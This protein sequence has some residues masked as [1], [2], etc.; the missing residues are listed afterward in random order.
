M[1]KTQQSQLYELTHKKTGQQIFSSSL[2]KIEQIGFQ[3]A[4]ANWV[5]DSKVHKEY[6]AKYPTIK[7]YDKHLDYLAKK[8]KIEFRENLID[9][10]NKYSVWNIRTVEKEYYNEQ[11]MTMNKY[12]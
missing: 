11:E 2:L 12:R 4:E 8:E 1:N 10:V 5:R 9:N 7:E 3:S 6:L